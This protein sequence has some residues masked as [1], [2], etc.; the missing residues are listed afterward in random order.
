MH[1]ATSKTLGDF[2]FEFFAQLP[3]NLPLE[4]R[5]SMFEQCLQCSNLPVLTHVFVALLLA[6]SHQRLLGCF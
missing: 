3:E 2:A 5:S 4:L 1:K 6:T